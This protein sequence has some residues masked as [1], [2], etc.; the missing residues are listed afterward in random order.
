MPLDE[1]VARVRQVM[2]RLENEA[3]AAPNVVFG[4][5]SHEEWIALNLRHAELHLGFLIPS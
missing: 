3:P 4:P 5:L 1:A 2:K